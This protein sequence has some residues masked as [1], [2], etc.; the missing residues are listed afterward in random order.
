VTVSVGEVVV[1]SESDVE[2][3]SNDEERTARLSQLIGLSSSLL[4]PI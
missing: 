3:E 4:R 1:E 2:V